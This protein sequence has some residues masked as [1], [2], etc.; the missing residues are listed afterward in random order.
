MPAALDF[1][2][3]SCG[4]RSTGGRTASVIEI[5]VLQAL[6]VRAT[7]DIRAALVPLKRALALAEPEGYLRVFADQGP[8]MAALLKAAGKRD[9]APAHVRRLLTALGDLSRAGRRSSRWPSP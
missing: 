4:P 5:L 2:D 7:G 3:T 1:L 6:A 8:E 9:I